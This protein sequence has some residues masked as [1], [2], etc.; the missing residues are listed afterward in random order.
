MS[1]KA[2][3]SVAPSAHAPE[4]VPL[5]VGQGESPAFGRK[6]LFAYGALGLP[7][8]F[9]ALPIYVH[10][11][12]LY[13]EGLGLPLTLV[14]T[15]LL[16]ARAV[17]AVTDPLLGW[18][19]DRVARRRGLIAVAMP[20]MVVA[21]FALLNPPSDAGAAWLAV[22]VF[23]VT[24]AYSLASINYHA[25]GAELGRTPF[26]RTRLV[27]HREG[28]ALAGVV[29]AAALPAMLA[30]DLRAGMAALAWLLVPIAL[31]AVITTLGGT[32]HWDGRRAADRIGGGMGERPLD[33]LSV[34]PYR[35]ALLPAVRVALGHPAFGRLLAVFA[36]NGIAAAIPATT[37]LFFVADV[38]EG[39]HWSGGFLALYFVS[40]AASLPLWVKL[41]ARIGK[42]RAWLWAMGL[43][44]GV[45]AW[46]YSLGAGD[47]L[48][49]ALICMLSGAALGADLMLPPAIVADVLAAE[50]VGA[51]PRAGVWFGLWNL[52]NKGNLA[53][54]AGLALPLLG[55]FGYAPGAREPAALQA[56]ATIYALLPVVFKLLAGYLLWCWRERLEQGRVV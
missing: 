41:S 23:G 43:A 52:V 28:C 36:A 34:P 21:L 11:P 4:P 50:P 39:D 48:A 22:S 53:L 9:A 25:W 24:L 1:L 40:A 46:A 12:R 17:D 19:S 10:T 55:S 20:A 5:A 16:A 2:K 30:D 8:A 42:V 37:V 44:V 14:G 15:V 45:F 35:A 32:P 26:E 38:L 29:M 51:E 47:L 54:A 6:A 7:L 3:A 18:L 56:L 13:A 31:L 27:A 49:F 33:G